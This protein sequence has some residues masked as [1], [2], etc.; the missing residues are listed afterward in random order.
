MTRTDHKALTYMKKTSKPISSQFQTWF[1]NLSGFDFDLIYWKGNEHGNADGLS[2]INEKLCTQCLT[3]HQEAN[4]NKSNIKFISGLEDENFNTED[5]RKIQVEDPVVGSIARWLQG[6]DVDLGVHVKNTKYYED[7]D[8][9][10][11]IE[12]VVVNM[13]Q[14]KIRIL[15]LESHSHKLIRYI[16]E[17]LCHLGS[18][19]LVE[20]I[21][22][23]YYWPNM[24][25]SIEHEIKKSG[26]KINNL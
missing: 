9:L 23:S 25:R 11:I 15:I 24:S 26:D 3:T 1:A 5:I 6:F 7:L 8:N 10:K 2:R 4:E 21:Q 16:H 14:N 22:E 13:A 19:K 12:N 17:E 20:Y 18:K